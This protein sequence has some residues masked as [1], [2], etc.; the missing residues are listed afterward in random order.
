MDAY[1]KAL[2]DF[3]VL[4]RRWASNETVRPTPANLELLAGYIRRE[5]NAAAKGLITCTPGVIVEI[6]ADAVLAGKVRAAIRRYEQA[7]KVEA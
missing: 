3:A 1:F 2:R 7:N 6:R 5:L 4:W